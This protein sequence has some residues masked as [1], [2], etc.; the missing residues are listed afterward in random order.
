MPDGYGPLSRTIALMTIANVSDLADVSDYRIDAME[1]TN[2]LT[3]QL[4]RNATCSVLGQDRRQSVLTLIEKACAEIL[5]VD[6]V[7]L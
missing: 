2:R 4:S 5:K 6:W 3:G 1:G 7:E